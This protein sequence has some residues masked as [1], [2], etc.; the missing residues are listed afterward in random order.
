MFIVPGTTVYDSY[1]N[2]YEVEQLIGSGGFGQVFKITSKNDGEIYAL[3]TLLFGFSDDMYL[4]SFLNEG[5]VST[6]ISHDNVV[7][8][9]YFHHTLLWNI[10]RMEHW[11]N[12]LK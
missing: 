3:K 6:S 1:G 10:P 8:Y 7:K 2:E 5:N 12:T 11:N 9:I 4:E